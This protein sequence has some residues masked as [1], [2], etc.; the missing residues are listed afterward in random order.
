MKLCIQGLCKDYKSEGGRI[1]A[2]DSP[3]GPVVA[4]NRLNATVGDK[5]T[6][7]VRPEFIRVGAP[8]TPDTCSDF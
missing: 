1:R 3:I 2:L 8:E 4:Q 7:C 5:A 6:V